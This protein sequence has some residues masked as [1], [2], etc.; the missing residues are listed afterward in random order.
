MSSV[1]ITSPCVSC[2]NAYPVA[3]LTDEL[4]AGCNEQNQ[5]TSGTLLELV[6]PQLIV[7]Y[8]NALFNE[9]RPQEPQT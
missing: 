8:P 7:T 2:L 6:R 9:A 4:C 1:P 3:D 5:S